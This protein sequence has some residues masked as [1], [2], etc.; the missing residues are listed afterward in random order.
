MSR[1]GV[2]ARLVPGLLLWG[3]LACSEQGVAPTARILA[4]ADTADQILEAMSTTIVRSGVRQSMV[5][6]DTA[7]I[8][9][10]AQLAVLANMRAVFFDA[11]G[12]ETSILTARSG[13]YW[14]QRG[15]LEARDSVVVVSAEGPRRR[16]TTSHLVYDVERNE[17]RSDSAFVYEGPDGLLRGSSFTSDPGFKRVVTRRPTGVQRGDGIILPGQ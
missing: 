15:A 10:D 8:Y 14:I 17:V 3:A 13:D 11:Q 4:A 16:L 6:A 2:T 5:Y 12:N 1:P 7:W 9:Q